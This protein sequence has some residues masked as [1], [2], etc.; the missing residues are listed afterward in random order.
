MKKSKEELESPFNKYWQNFFKKF[1]T[2]NSLPRHLWNYQEF[3]AYF[4][5]RFQDHYKRNFSFSL[6]GP[7]SKCQELFL[8]KK[9]CAMLNTNDPNKIVA[10]IDWMFDKKIIPTN[11]KLTSIGF[12]TMP[13]FGNE[14]GYWYEENNTIQ[15]TTDLPIEY[16]NLA[17]QMNLPILT[18]SDL[19]F[20]H[21][22]IQSNPDSIS[23]Q[24]YKDFLTQIQT[25]G[26]DLNIL[27]DLK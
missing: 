10:Y 14:F 21:Q 11:K 7:P 27:K 20:A 25:M 24:P 9:I 16:I 26:M 5:K 8:I 4:C 23:R 17:K 12:L 2:I 18:Y 3:L 1:D 19:A 15:K 6:S 13:N 22:A